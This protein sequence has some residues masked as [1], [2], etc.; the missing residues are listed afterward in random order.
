MISLKKICHARAGGHLSITIIQ[1]SNRATED[2]LVQ[3]N[4]FSIAFSTFL[5]VF[6]WLLP[7]KYLYGAHNKPNNVR[8]TFCKSFEQAFFVLVY[9]LRKITS[10]ASIKGSICL[11][12]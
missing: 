6:L 8:C 9:S 5:F 3:S 2:Y 4:L 12:G 10:N 1:C 7:H 11:A